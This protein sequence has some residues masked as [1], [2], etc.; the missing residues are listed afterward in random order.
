MPG[1]AAHD[2]GDAIRFAA[3]TAVEDEPDTSKVA[4]NMD[5]YRAFTRGFLEACGSAL[6]HLEVETMALGAVA[7]TIEL[8]SRFLADH[9]D[10]D[11]YFR[12]HRPNH[13]LE[14]ARCQIALAQDMLAKFD[15]MQAIVD[16]SART[17]ARS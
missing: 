4:L 1:L 8:A 11:N 16:E 7:I 13:N 2:F 15:D 17:P 14:R 10:G 3:N 12:I 9:I 5:N 6:T